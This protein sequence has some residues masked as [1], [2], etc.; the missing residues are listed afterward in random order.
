VKAKGARVAAD[1]SALHSDRSR[2]S[3]SSYD[4]AGVTADIA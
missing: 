1:W 4:N 2:V 3:W